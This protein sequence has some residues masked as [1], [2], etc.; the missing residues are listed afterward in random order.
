MNID[1]TR[2]Y[3]I[4]RV[5]D[6][7]DNDTH[8]AID[9]AAAFPSIAAMSARILDQA[10]TLPPAF[11]WR[12]TETK[13]QVEEEALVLLDDFALNEAVDTWDEGPGRG[14]KYDVIDYLTMRPFDPES[15]IALL[16]GEDLLRLDVPQD[17]WSYPY[18]VQ[19]IFRP[20]DT[21]DDVFVRPAVWAHRD[22]A[23]RHVHEFHSSGGR[24]PWAK[25]E[26]VLTSFMAGGAR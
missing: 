7:V 23:G 19:L 12:G 24:I 10:R 15:E 9:L 3:L 20:T 5:L 11:T 13:V 6:D 18:C 1:K 4:Y 2:K 21:G 8:I 14:A 16:T 25:L 22:D 17:V 26:R